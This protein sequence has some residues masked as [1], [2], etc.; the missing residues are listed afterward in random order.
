MTDQK[1]NKYKALELRLSQKHNKKPVA[2]VYEH[3]KP[4]R[5]PLKKE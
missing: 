1:G 4:S 5:G 2:G 3:E